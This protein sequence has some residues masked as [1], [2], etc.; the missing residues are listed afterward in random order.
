MKKVCV[1]LFSGTGLTKYAIDTIKRELE[2]LSV[3][4]DVYPIETTSAQS[5][6]FGTYDALGIAYPVHAFNAPKIVINFAKTLPKAVSTNVFLISTAGDDHPI[7]D[8]SSK[9]LTR[10]LQRKN[11][12]VFYDKLLNMPS[13]FV[14]KYDEPK[15]ERLLSA[16]DSAAPQIAK[17]IA[18]LVPCKQKSGFLSNIMAFVG[19]AEWF[20]TVF[21][22]KTFFADQN[23]THCGVCVN[24]CPNRN[25]VN[26]NRIRFRWHCGLCMRCLYVCPQH[27]IRVHWP[28]RFICFDK[29]YQNE[30][31]RQIRKS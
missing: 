14:V 24:H 5:V 18:S 30:K 20:G 7:N 10:I 17:E 29:W 31:I 15:V 26:G 1:F 13:N 12:H 28:F 23:C 25:I 8:S 2:N 21:I 22:G 4:V 27:A 9:L 19:R 6:P 16:A 11:Y 3:S